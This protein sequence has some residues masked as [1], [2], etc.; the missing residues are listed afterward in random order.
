MHLIVVQQPGDICIDP[1]IAYQVFGE[2]CRQLG[3]DV[4]AGMMA[5]IR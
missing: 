1:I 3:G 5:L 2:A 4:L